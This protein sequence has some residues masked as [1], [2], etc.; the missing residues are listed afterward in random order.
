MAAI[1]AERGNGVSGHT[2]QSVNVETIHSE[3]GG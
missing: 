2:A 3:N 1:R